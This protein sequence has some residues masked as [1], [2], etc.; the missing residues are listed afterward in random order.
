M[1]RKKPSI[2]FRITDADGDQVAIVLGRS[3][4]GAVH[5]AKQGGIHAARH[6]YALPDLSR[7]RE[8]INY[9]PKGNRE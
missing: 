9:Q 2:V 7:K 3:P 8:A 4:R 1:S 5:T 6:A